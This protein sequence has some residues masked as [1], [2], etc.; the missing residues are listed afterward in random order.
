MEAV[1]RVCAYDICPHYKE[2]RD[3]VHQVGKGLVTSI[4]WDSLSRQISGAKIKKNLLMYKLSMYRMHKKTL[5]A[6]EK[7][8]P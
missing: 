2:D 7:I 3:I 1:K 6:I 8:L 5:R 4:C